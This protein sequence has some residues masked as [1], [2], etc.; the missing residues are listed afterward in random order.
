MYL[1]K[2]STFHLTKSE[3]QKEKPKNVFIEHCIWRCMFTKKIGF[4]ALALGQ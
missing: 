4:A 1:A 2:F 3:C